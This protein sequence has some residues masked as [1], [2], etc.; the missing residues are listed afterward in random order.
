[1]QLNTTQKINGALPKHQQETCHTFHIE[2]L[3]LG[4]IPYRLWK[5]F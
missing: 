4:K 5:T 1:M 3:E 2:D